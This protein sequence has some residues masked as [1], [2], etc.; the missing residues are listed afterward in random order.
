MYNTLGLKEKMSFYELSKDEH[1]IQY[2]LPIF[3]SNV[4]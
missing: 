3:G 4:C 2:C 1:F